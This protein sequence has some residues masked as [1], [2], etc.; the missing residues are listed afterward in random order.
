MVEK[1]RQN[2]PHNGMNL[3]SMWIT[4]DE[5]ESLKESLKSPQ[6]YG[7]NIVEI[8]DEAETRGDIKWT[9]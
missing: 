9:K 4:K 8:L 6:L 5:E 2:N 3:I 1:A 7:S